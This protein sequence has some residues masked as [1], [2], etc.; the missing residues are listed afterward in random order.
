MGGT[1]RKAFEVRE[2]KKKQRVH[3]ISYMSEYAQVPLPL[4]RLQDYLVFNRSPSSLA[5]KAAGSLKTYMTRASVQMGISSTP[6]NVSAMG[7]NKSLFNGNQTGQKGYNMF[8]NTSTTQ[9]SM[10]GQKPNGMTGNANFSMGGSRNIPLPGGQSSGTGLFNSNNNNM[11]RGMMG[12][13]TMGMTGMQNQQ[14]QQKSSMFPS[15]GGGTGGTSLFNKTGMGVNNPMSRGNQNM[16]QSTLFN[17]NK[18]AMGGGSLFNSNNMGVRNNMGASTNTS[19]GLFNSNTQAKP[20]GAGLFNGNQSTLNKPSSLFNAQNGMKANQ[21]TSTLF[22]IGGSNN[23]NQGGGAS[24]LFQS[25]PLNNTGGSSLFNNGM[26]N[27]LNKTGGATGLF[28]K[29]MG[30]ASG[31]QGYFNNK[32]NVPGYQNQRGGSSLF[33]APAMANQGRGNSQFGPM[34]GPQSQMMMPMMNPAMG[35]GYAMV[36]VPLGN[37]TANANTSNSNLQ[38]TNNKVGQAQNKNNQVTA[39]LAK[40]LKSSGYSVG[41]DPN[42]Q[43]Q[44]SVNSILEQFKKFDTN[45]YQGRQPDLE[46]DSLYESMLSTSSREGPIV[47]RSEDVNYLRAKSNAQKVLRGMRRKNRAMSTSKS[48]KSSNLMPNMDSLNGKWTNERTRKISDDEPGKVLGH[49]IRLNTNQSS[50]EPLYGQHSS[51]NGHISNLDLAGNARNLSEG[52]YDISEIHKSNVFK[53]K[54]GNDNAEYDPAAQAQIEIDVIL[55]KFGKDSKFRFK[56]CREDLISSILVLANARKL[57]SQEELAST[58]V[59][60]QDSALDLTATIASQNLLKSSSAEPPTVYLYPKG[61]LDRYFADTNLVPVLE[62]KGYVCKPSIIELSRMTESELSAVEKFEIWNLFGKIVFESPVDLRSADLDK[63]VN[64]A[65][66]FVE[67]YDKTSCPIP[68]KGKGLNVPAMITYFGYRKKESISEERFL[69]TLKKQARK[70]KAQFIS[71][72]ADEGH[73]KIMVD[74]F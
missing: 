6:S 62:R 72:K 42:A 74:H 3:T 61:G 29:P 9:N 28:N 14:Q 8:N 60:F 49:S 31:S 10:F 53:K 5:P 54:N 70:I 68:A 4:L 66:K 17:N 50:N 58:M 59:I 18:A 24:S 63:I 34:Q 64:I 69:K 36:C 20:M 47:R 11:Q 1:S 41:P 73:L 33:N 55:Q 25:K 26:N 51:R 27:N 32:Q 44:D 56:L 43:T 39:A 52:L 12:Q 7:Q 46:R 19:N 45:H 22:N 37:N 35:G 16:A 2:N 48:L 15:M 23:K 40:L 38:S 13:N 21:T 30:Q 67:V 71:Y 65:H 57:L